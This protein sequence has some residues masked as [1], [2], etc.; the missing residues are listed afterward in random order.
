MPSEIVGAYHIHTLFSDGRKSPSDIAKLASK[1]SLDFI[2]LTDHG[3]PNRESLKVQGWEEDVLV[4]AGSELSVSRGH[5]VA[6][7][8]DGSDVSF[9]Q[10]TEIAVHQIR[11]S[12]G[13]SIIAHPYSKTRWSWGKSIEYSGLE[14]INADTML[15]QSF[16]GIIPYLPSLL[17][18]PKYVLLKMLQKPD[19][20][21][22]KWD[23]MNSFRP[24]YGYYS[25]DIHIFYRPMLSVLKLHVILSDPLSRD[26][27]AAKKQVFNALREG[28]FYN[29]VD[30]AAE[31]GGFRFWG[32][33][34]G[35]RIPMGGNFALNSPAALHIRS[36]FPF[37]TETRLLH[38]GNIICRSSEDEFIY[39]AEEPGHYR[40]EVYLKERSPLNEDVPWIL[41]NPIFLG[42]KEQ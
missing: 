22:K 18:A 41:S 20:N 2:I 23:G 29:A 3:R 26:F 1:E 21:L 30:A 33:S 12:E 38:E 24:V 31:A 36:P 10:E 7:G 37:S 25:S 28:R 27:D 32:E 11:A 35:I 40:V 13:F 6:L 19:K 4:L 14:I 42:E 8:F 39:N 17:I 9:S 16:S 5:L 34:E 15:K